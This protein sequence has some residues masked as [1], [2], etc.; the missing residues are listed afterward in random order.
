MTKIDPDNYAQRIA[1]QFARD[2]IPRSIPPEEAAAICERYRAAVD[3]E[4][5]PVSRRELAR[6]IAVALAR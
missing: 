6:L 2:G 5:A 1:D 4:A 3:I